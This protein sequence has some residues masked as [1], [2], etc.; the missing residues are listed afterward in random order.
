MDYLATY[1]DGYIWYHASDMQLH[2]YMDT[3][4]IVLPKSHSRIAG[5]ITSQTHHTQVTDFL[6]MVLY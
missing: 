5:F 1:L 2:K 6:G 4:Y 3:A